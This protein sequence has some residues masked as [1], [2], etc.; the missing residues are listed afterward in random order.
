[1]KTLLFACFVGI[2][3]LV[4]GLIVFGRIDGQKIPFERTTLEKIDSFEKALSVA[5]TQPVVVY[6]C[7]AGGFLVGL[8][9]GIGLWLAHRGGRTQISDIS[10]AGARSDVVPARATKNAAGTDLEKLQEDRP[11]IC[12]L[13]SF[14]TLG[15]YKFY[16]IPQGKALVVMAMG[17]YRKSCQ[18]GLCA[19]LSFWGLYQHPYKDMPLIECKEYAL[20]YEN[21][22]VVSSDGI[23]CS[24]T[25]MI[26]HRIADPGKV[27][28]EV[29]NWQEAMGNMVR[30][31]LRS[32]YAKQP[33]QSLRA[34]RE[35]MARTLRETLER[36][37]A[38]W[39]IKIRIVEITN[40]EI[41]TSQ[42]NPRLD[43]IS[44]V[45]PNT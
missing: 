26:C 14:L 11:A 37:V 43:H 2:T 8:L 31:V 45:L 41:S 35:Q 27:L 10:T 20:A 34:S 39:G 7:G 4:V 42:T 13:L 29:D 3:G 36:C 1:M 12:K 24:L 30:A 38:P 17:K 23:K 33:A 18:P 16:A 9:A 22:S 5:K 21:Q 28:F 32:E 6:A 19:L 15:I 25:V 44:S 40:L